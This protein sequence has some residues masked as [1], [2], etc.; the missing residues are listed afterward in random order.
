M[1]GGESEM[2]MGGKGGKGKRRQKNSSVS[3]SPGN[4]NK[5][6]IKIII[7]NEFYYDTDHKNVSCNHVFFFKP[8]FYKY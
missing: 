4:T 2:K 3:S 7:L 1:D 6:G 5:E 8:N